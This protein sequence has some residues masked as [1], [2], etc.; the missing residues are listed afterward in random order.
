MGKWNYRPRRRNYRQQNLWS[1]TSPPPQF[2]SE[3]P[4]QPLQDNVPSWE[5]RFCCVIGSVPWRKLVAAKKFMSCHS[6]ILDWDDSAV[7]EAFQNAKWRFWA[8]MNGLTCDV[9][10]PDPDIYIDKIDWNPVIDPELMKELDQAYF[11]PPDDG[12]GNGKLWRKDKKIRNSFAAPS[13]GNS[14]NQVD[15]VNPWECNN[16]EFSGI[17][18][19]KEHGWNQWNDPI[20]TSKDVD[21][22]DTSLD[23][24]TTR[25]DRNVQDKAWGD[26][27]K[28]SW[29]NSDCNKRN[30]DNNEDAPSDQGKT[31]WDNSDRN[32]RSC[33]NNNNF[34]EH[35]YRDCI[36]RKGNGWDSIWDK[37]DW[38]WNRQ[39]WNSTTN[40]DDPWVSS[41]SQHLRA[42]NDRGWRNYGGDGARC[43]KQWDCHNNQNKDFDIRKTSSRR[44]AWK[45]D[46]QRKEGSHNNVSGYK[47]SRFRGHENQTVDCW[48]RGNNKKRVSFA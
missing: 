29:D 25:G 48:R 15:G 39:E 44:E 27:G 35:S 37:S 28:T 26:H 30:C 8:E 3:L 31:S 12:E 24:N 4:P 2:D 38:G 19:N 5:K 18:Q 42:Q 13:G 47:S 33:N 9:S 11:A 7:E 21:N 43:W 16:A 1:W 34:W 14:T 23:F 45:G 20:N 10:L 40:A 22:N 6:N 41:S 32:K 46:F 17:S 36:S